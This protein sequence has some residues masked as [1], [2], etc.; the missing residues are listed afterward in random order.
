MQQKKAIVTV[1]H[2]DPTDDE[3]V[4][5]MD[6]D[7]ATPRTV[8]VPVRHYGRW[9]AGLIFAAIG[10]GIVYAFARADI[11]YEM[12]LS[13]LTDGLIITGM[14]HTLELTV[15]AMILALILGVGAAVM[16]QS[17]NPVLKVVAAFYAWLFRGTPLLV[18]LLI[19]YNLSIVFKTVSIPGIYRARCGKCFGVP[20]A[21]ALTSVV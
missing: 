4:R 19:W 17:D 16:R 13:Y 12:V 10:V 20:P 21:W 6:V 9:L 18:Q 5:V 8:V 14:I 7:E 1:P 3:L 15:L 2:P 11:D